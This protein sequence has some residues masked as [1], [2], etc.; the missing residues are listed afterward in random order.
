M[1]TPVIPGI[2]DRGLGIS[3]A[4][5]ALML[6]V[7]APVSLYGQ[8]MNPPNPPAPQRGR[9]NPT[10]P[11]NSTN[12]T[13]P[14]APPR[15]SGAANPTNSTN[16]TNPT[17]P[18]NPTNLTP[19]LNRPAGTDVAVPPIECW[20]KT[21]RS[22]VTIGQNFQ[23]TLTCAVLATERVSVVVDES[24]LEPSA[25]HLTPF[26][27]VGGQ[28]FREILNSPRKF[29]QYQY[30]MRVLGEEFFGREVLLPRLQISYRVQNSLQGGAALQGREAQYSLVPIPIRVLSLVP[31]GTNDIRDTP[32]DTFGDV[33]ARLFRSN[34]LLIGAG[35]AFVLAGLLALMLVARA[36]V[37]RRATAAVRQR[38]VSPISVLQAAL[39]ELRTV[40]AHSQR[41]GWNA[42]LAGRAAAALRLAGAVA[43][44]RPVSQT[45]VNRDTSPS[46]GQ[47]PAPPGLGTLRGKTTMLS[48]AVT[49]ESAVSN[50]NSRT[51]ELWRSLRQSLGA[52]T[53]AR[54][55][56]PSTT[57]ASSGSTASNVERSTS[58]GRPEPV[59]GRNGTVDGAALDAALAEGEDAIKRLRVRQV[60][61]FGRRKPHTETASARPTWAR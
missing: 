37:K 25:L 44:S 20:W 56:R 18:T 1:I 47:I 13:N 7:L 46:E 19:I 54:Y 6:A 2:R 17:N 49:P 36:A 58:S 61:R 60:L 27:I 52:F 9:A 48:A 3:P 22:A 8:A 31:P 55:T 24:S 33:E 12:Q 16:Q 57:S 14:P 50:G 45:V 39:R 38:T 34:L 40:R 23:L 43:L 11:T 21:D 10:N 5:I 4:S 35:V 26:E 30:T 41:D 28:R 51:S 42:E 59:E 32:L 53:A 29:F 15:R